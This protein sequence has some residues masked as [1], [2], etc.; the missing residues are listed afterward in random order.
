MKHALR[1]I[2]YRLAFRVTAPIILIWLILGLLLYFFA[3]SAATDFLSAN[4]QDDMRWLSRQTTS[5]CNAALD[6]V[7][8]TGMAANPN[9]VK[10]YQNRAMLAIEDFMREFKVEG[11][12]RSDQGRTLFAT[13][14]PMKDEQIAT[15][16]TVEHAIYTL[17]V[18]NNLYYYSSV[19]FDPWGWNITLVKSAEA[20][21]EFQNRMIRVYLATGGV[22]SAAVLL[23]IMLVHRSVNTPV[24]RIIDR[25]ADGRKPDYRGVC[26]IEFLSDNIHQMMTTLEQLNKHLEDMVKERTRELA[27]AKEEAEYATRAKSDFLARMSHEIRTPMNAIIGFTNLATKT[28]LSPEQKDYLHNVREAS[29]YLLNIINDILDFSKIEAGK[30]ELSCRQFSI[31]RILDKAADLFQV[32]AAEKNIELFFKVHKDVPA[33]LEGDSTRVGQI[34]I[35]LVANAIKFTDQGEVVV[36]VQVD[37]EQGRPE[38]GA[39]SVRLLCSVMDTGIGIARDKIPELF[40]PFTQAD[41][42]INRQHEGTGLG[43]SICQRLIEKM[44]GRIWVESAIG[45]GT[46]CFFTIVL[47]CR[48][49]RKADQLLAPVAMRRLNVL[50]VDPNATSARI[51]GQMLDD[52]GYMARTTQSTNQAMA[53]VEESMAGKPFDLVILAHGMQEMD[54][55]AVAGGIKRR[56]E[57]SPSKKSPKILLVS[58]YDN[59]ACEA[60][61]DGD[62]DDI[63]GW[64]LKPISSSKLFSAVMEAFGHHR[65]LTAVASQSDSERPLPGMAKL[66]GARVLLVEDNA[67]NRKFARAQL[68][69][70]G[71]QVDVAA[72]GRAAVERLKK[73]LCGGRPGYDAVLMDIEMPVMDGYTATRIIRSN[74]SFD[75]LP[76][77]AMTA[78]AMK[79]IEDKCMDAG[80][81]AYISKPVD[82]EQLYQTLA[83]H[84]AEAVKEDLPQVCQ[85]SAT[86]EDAWEQMPA[87]IDQI[88][89]NQALDRIG[90]NTGL[91]RRI[92]RRFVDQFRNADKTV[93]QYL[94]K[95][96]MDQARRLVHTIKG[97]AGNIGADGLFAAAR[98]LD[99]QLKNHSIDGIDAVLGDFL[100]AHQRLIASL[101]RLDLAPPIGG[102]T[103]AQPGMPVD[104][105]A[106]EALIYDMTELLKKSDSRARHLLPKLKARL[107][108]TALDTELEQLDRAIYRL[109]SDWALERLSIIAGKLQRAVGDDKEP[110]H[111]DNGQNTG[112]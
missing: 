104:V 51:M 84:L 24:G 8:K 64:L 82:E 55:M 31:N 111:A 65:H 54:A 30:L 86:A 108:G 53:L 66:D 99:S 18:K 74:P 42:S 22:L 85:E 26:E 28:E 5:I 11:F 97:T 9:I 37:P 92:L 103:P 58:S 23:I 87:Q 19:H 68:K 39:S 56:L 13:P 60:G 112:C 40:Q 81:N 1:K 44:G 71:L 32:K 6:E 80:M 89:L 7:L 105:E 46:T 27:Q 2:T 15:T 50:V 41:G 76:I 4:V 14:L 21:A 33:N 47:K 107:A 45:R 67:I 49:T 78:H 96:E 43:L 77:I 109:D 61:R 93:E 72:D 12:I 75:G 52:F 63:D 25:L 91:Y 73:S 10:I 57:G 69:I 90:G 70:L 94:A 106:A 110:S 100:A 88:N 79:G 20:Y 102:K 83:K 17:Q 98:E 3:H 59:K 62:N 29:H 101:Q 16:G 48:A 38:S 35:N 36:S 34:F 95:N